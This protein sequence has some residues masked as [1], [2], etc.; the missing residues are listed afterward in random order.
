MQR[1][2]WFKCGIERKSWRR[3]VGRR[4][5]ERYFVVGLWEGAKQRG[6]SHAFETNQEGKRSI[7]NTTVE[8]LGREGAMQ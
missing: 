1:W 4:K 3:E 6:R 2:A 5:I 7:N 8:L